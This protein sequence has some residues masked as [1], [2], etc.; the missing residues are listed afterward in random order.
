M[1]KEALQSVI[2][3]LRE[4]RTPSLSVEDFP[5]LLARG[6]R[7][8]PARGAD[9]SRRG[10]EKPHG[11]RRAHVRARPARDG[12]GR[13]RLARFQDRLRCGRGS[14]QHRQRGDEEVRRRGLG[15]RRAARVLLQQR[16]G[17]RGVAAVFAPRHVPDEGRHA[18]PLDAQRAVRGSH[19]GERPSVRP[20]ACLAAGR[21]R[22]G[23]RSGGARRPRGLRR[24]G[25]RLRSGLCERSA[26][27]CGEAHRARGR[28]LRRARAVPSLPRITYACSRA[29]TCSTPR[30]ASGRR[31]MP[32]T[33]WA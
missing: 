1:N 27:P 30:A 9:V 33:T 24:D 8:Q 14:A 5:V 25:G 28:Q 3:A 12:G 6:D 19:L 21:V 26:L 16:E 18:R 10:G 32:C 7:R 29:A 11:R 15:R 22:R 13:P 2:A 20:G 17:D 23:Q 31:S 4:G